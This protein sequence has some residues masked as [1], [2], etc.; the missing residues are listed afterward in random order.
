MLKN[1][2]AETINPLA[3]NERNNPGQSIAKD[4]MQLYR[5][6]VQN[7]SASAR[8]PAPSNEISYKDMKPLKQRNTNAPEKNASQLSSTKPFQSVQPSQTKREDA[9]NQSRQTYPA[10]KADANSQPKQTYPV[11]K[12][13]AIKQSGQITP[14]KKMEVENQQSKQN[15]QSQKVE[16]NKQTKEDNSPKKETGL[17]LS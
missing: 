13:N 4:Q 7:N 17:K 9:I 8:K 6:N 1:T 12:D 16:E 3:I 15:K 11:K 2:W 5:P 10:K 14:I